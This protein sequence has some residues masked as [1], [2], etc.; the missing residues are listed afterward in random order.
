MGHDFD[1]SGSL[2]DLGE[3]LGA[4]GAE[5]RLVGVDGAQVHLRLDL[6]KVECMDCV[7]PP[8]LLAELVRD[9]L[10]RRGPPELDVVLDDPRR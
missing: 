6:S 10:R 2:H 9:G 3:L 5:L 7:I 1:L 8:E 4:E